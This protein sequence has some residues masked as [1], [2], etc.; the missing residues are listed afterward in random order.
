MSQACA[1]KCRMRIVDT[2]V[3]ESNLDHGGLYICL[4]SFSGRRSAD[5]SCGN[6]TAAGVQMIE[7]VHTLRIERL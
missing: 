2:A 5:A 3:D 4:R 6:Y 7:V 1:L